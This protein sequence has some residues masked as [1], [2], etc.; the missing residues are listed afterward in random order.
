MTLADSPYRNLIPILRDWLTSWT[1]ERGF[2]EMARQEAQERRRRERS[3]DGDPREHDE[4]AGISINEWKAA[5]GEA[6]KLGYVERDATASAGGVRVLYR[7][8]G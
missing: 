3:G 8:R 2:A 4:V 5:L 1:T 7:R 6:V